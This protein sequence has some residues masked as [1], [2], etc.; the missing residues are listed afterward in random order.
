MKD[1]YSPITERIWRGHIEYF[2]TF[3]FI[4][5]VTSIYMTRVTT[6][7]YSLFISILYIPLFL[8]YFI[9]FLWVFFSTFELLHQIRMA[10][11]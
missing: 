8:S 5:I 3:L 1:R 7:Q 9:G 6:S 4:V 10:R 11:K 2:C